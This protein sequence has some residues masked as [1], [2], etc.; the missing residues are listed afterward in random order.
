MSAGLPW[1]RYEVAHH[2]A[3][4]GTLS[5]AARGLD[6]ALQLDAWAA[7]DGACSVEV[8]RVHAHCLRDGLDGKKLGAEL[9]ASGRWVLSEDRQWMRCPWLL[10]LRVVAAAGVEQKRAAG[11]ESGRKRKEEAEAKRAQREARR[12]GAKGNNVRGERPLNDRSTPD[13]PAPHVSDSVSSE[14]PSNALSPRDLNDRSTGAE[15]I[16]VCCSP[17]V[18][19]EPGGEQPALAG[20]SA[21]A[22][23]VAGRA[24]GATGPAAEREVR[25]APATPTRIQPG[26]VLSLQAAQVLEALPA[27]P[28]EFDGA[29]L[30]FVGILEAAAPEVDVQRA[31]FRA[32]AA[33]Q[34][35]GRTDGHAPLLD[36]I[37]GLLAGRGGRAGFLPVASAPRAIALA[38]HGALIMPARLQVRA[39]RGL[40]IHIARDL[41]PD[42][43]DPLR[44][45]CWI[46]GEWAHGKR[47]G[48]YRLAEEPAPERLLP[49]LVGGR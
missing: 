23:P 15:Q 14:S 33:W 10:E 29:M 48:D 19:S 44:V 28:A 24:G 11:L 45:A 43:P 39:L 7:A 26:H 13:N 49:L 12:R 5:L 41:A 16:R 31:L 6:A 27:P 4:C 1:Y 36:E 32:C 20:A 35:G 40:A 3:S 22:V 21:A 37:T 17:P 9:I 42:E 34:T 30:G 8:S 18:L 38:L 47:H 2:A 46:A 25:E